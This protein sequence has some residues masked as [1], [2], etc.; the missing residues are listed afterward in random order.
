MR[1]FVFL[2][3]CCLPAI[4]SAQVGGEFHFEFT[5]NP[6]LWDLSGAYVY[7]NAV[8]E[9]EN[10]LLHAPNGAVRGQD[11][12]RYHDGINSFRATEISRGRV[13]GDW[14]SGINMN[15]AGAGQF[16][17]RAL[18][19]PVEGPFK[20]TIALDLDSEN[21]TISGTESA[22]LCVGNFGC[23]TIA[24]NTSYE[25]P[26]QMNGAWSLSLN[27]TTNRTAVRGSA[28]VL[29]SNGR[30]F[31]L[32]VRGRYIAATG[33]TRLNLIGTRNARGVMV[34]LELNANGAIENIGGKLFGQRLGER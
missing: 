27:L 12:V 15:V 20:G 21:R 19:R 14:Q 23:R 29:L 1:C 24:T 7:S 22:T 17:G 26:V 2:L 11:T 30:S 3:V 9:S 13:S 32:K 18:G 6:P 4:T 25:L 28:M 16:T 33:V 5:N 34:P 10:T 8:V 31:S